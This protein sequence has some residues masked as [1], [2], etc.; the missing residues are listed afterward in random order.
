MCSGLFVQ[1][2]RVN[3]LS[4]VCICQIDWIQNLFAKH[5]G[6]KQTNIMKYKKCIINI[7]ILYIIPT[8]NLLKS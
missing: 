3:V 6:S 7:F 1:I 4:A 5:Q 8:R 2:L